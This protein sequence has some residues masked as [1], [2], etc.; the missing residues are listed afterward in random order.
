MDINE[1]INEVFLKTIKM[2]DLT[3][4]FLRSSLSYFIDEEENVKGETKINDD[5]VDRSLIEI[6]KTCLNIILRERPFALDLRRVTGIFKLVDDIERLGDHSEDIA[7]CVSNLKKAQIKQN[8]KSKYLLEMI[9]IS[10]NMVKD[11]YNGLLKNDD[12]LALRVLKTDD[13]VDDL[14]LKVLNELSILKE[15]LANNDYFIYMTL[16]AKYVERLADHASN[17]AE[18]VIYIKSGYYKDEVII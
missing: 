5:L 1:K 9:E 17:I 3:I 14:Y 18:W 12:K 8:V 11:A 2:Y 10:F 6:E 16:I 7:W 15:K 4:E 13:T